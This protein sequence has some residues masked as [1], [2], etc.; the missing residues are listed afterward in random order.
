MFFAMD[1]AIAATH[2]ALDYAMVRASMPAGVLA[3]CLASSY[4]SVLVET[5]HLV[6]A[7]A[8]G[9]HETADHI[10]FA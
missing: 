8:V 4:C 9:I 1:R 10:G 2:A 3:A 6:F 7:D 5:L